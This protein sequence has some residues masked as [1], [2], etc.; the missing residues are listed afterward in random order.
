M[1]AE[2][3]EELIDQRFGKLTVL[4]YAGKTKGGRAQY[5]CKCDCGKEKKVDKYALLDGKRK[6]CGCERTYNKI[7]GREAKKMQA[8]HLQLEDLQKQ[9]VVIK[10]DI[11][12]PYAESLCNKCIRSAAPPSLQC[13][14]DMSKAQELPDGAVVYAAETTCLGHKGRIGV[15]VKV[16]ECPLFADITIPENNEL[17]REERKKNQK[18]IELNN[19]GIW[20]N[21]NNCKNKNNDDWR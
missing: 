7:A 14:W 12:N 5:I 4:E 10:N 1:V 21:I 20:K 17:L 9:N 11:K 6:D 8:Q 13:I 19:S 3:H 16:L 18:R 2:K 15:L